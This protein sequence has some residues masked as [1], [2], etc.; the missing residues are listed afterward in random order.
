MQSKTN[1][2]S[3]WDRN[4]E[5]TLWLVPSP[6]MVRGH[7]GCGRGYIPALAGA[8]QRNRGGAC[9]PDHGGMV[10]DPGGHSPVPVCRV[11][12]R[13]L[14]RLLLSAAGAYIS[15]GGAAGVDR[16]VVVRGELRDRGPAGGKGAQPDPQRRTA[17]GRRGA[18]LHS[19]PGDDASRRRSAP[20]SRHAAPD[21]TQFR[22]GNA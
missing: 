13:P 1:H 6:A 10:R 5:S 3:G 21:R 2:G 9:L 4:D 15:I 7:A 19:Q 14:F 18:T 22:A 8:S 20:D 12:L 17:P 16:N 11:A